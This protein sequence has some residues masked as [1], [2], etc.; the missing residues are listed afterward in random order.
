MKIPIANCNLKGTPLSKDTVMEV[1]SII[2]N[3]KSIV[4]DTE[5]N[6]LY[7]E[8]NNHIENESVPDKQYTGYI[9]SIRDKYLE[10]FYQTD[11]KVIGYTRDGRV[12][13][14]DQNGEVIETYVSR[15]IFKD[16][17]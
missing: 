4:R 14:E 5:T 15:L 3:N 7:E 6:R 11:Y 10:R 1:L 8:Y 13:L 2:G 17:V 9:V 16:Y 12:K